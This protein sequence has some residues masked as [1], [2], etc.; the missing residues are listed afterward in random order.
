MKSSFSAKLAGLRTLQNRFD[1]KSISEKSKLL[2]LLK[3]DALPASKSLSDY[4]YTLLFLS[5]HPANEVQRKHCADELDRLAQYFKKLGKGALKW[6]NTGFP[7]TCI[8]S[9]FSHKFIKWLVNEEFPVSLEE[10]DLKGDDLLQILKFTLPDLERDLVDLAESNEELFELLGLQKSQWLEFLI[11]EFQRLDSLGLVR[12]HLF[13]A[14]GLSFRI[15]LNDPSASIPFNTMPVDAYYYHA[16]LLKQ[17]DP[18]ILLRQE[19]SEP[20][21]LSLEMKGA[22]PR[23][24]RLKLMFLQRET[25]PCTHLDPESIRYY[26]LERGV[27]IA[28]YTMVPERQLPLESYVGYTLFKNGYPAAY[29]G[30]WVFGSRAL[31]GI[32]VFE[33]F[34]GGESSYL[35]WQLL[36]VYHQV[37]GVT[38]FEVEPYQFGLNNDEGIDSGAF[39]FYYRNGFRPDDSALA[40]LADAEF[41]KMQ[42]SKSYKSSKSVLQKLTGGNISLQLGSTVPMALWEIRDQ[43]S[44]YI[45]KHFNGNRYRAERACI[46]AF[47]QKTGFRRPTDPE[48]RKVLAD[49]SL[50]YEALEWNSHDQVFHLKEMI[51]KKPK[52]LYRYQEE[53]L[54]LLSISKIQ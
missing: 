45:N 53:L 10:I 11:S 5:A 48:F 18:K 51:L 1:E 36:R 7:Y 16:D 2:A 8:V 46:Q 42:K 15:W 44:E 39:W 21:F 6:D 35:L 12:D 47:L 50:I 14:L 23:I 32:N 3:C 41:K 29:G 49:V 25:D 37:F 22:I 17:F 52:D 27:S 33:W 19:I 13:D 34:R 43:V 30:S 31:F 20:E 40:R 9:N 28:L 26:N 38:Y 54:K 4:L 24:V